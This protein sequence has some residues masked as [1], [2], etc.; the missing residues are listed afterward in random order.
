[1]TTRREPVPS[2]GPVAGTAAGHAIGVAPGVLPPP[3]PAN[4]RQNAP[5][6]KLEHSIATTSAPE[7][8][9]LAQPKPTNELYKRYAEGNG[10]SLET[11]KPGLFSRMISG[12]KEIAHS[13]GEHLESGLKKGIAIG[14]SALGSVKHAVSAAF[15]AIPEWGRKVTSGISS[16]WE[17]VK[18]FVGHSFDT[19]SKGISSFVEKAESALSAISSW[20]SSVTSKVSSWFSSSSSQSEESGFFGSDA[21]VVSY[22]VEVAKQA[23][24]ETEK[25]ALEAAARSEAAKQMVSGTLEYGNDAAVSAKLHDIYATPQDV[26][27]AVAVARERAEAE[28]LKASIAQAESQSRAPGASVDVTRRIQER[29][30][31][32]GNKAS[33]HDLTVVEKEAIKKEASGST[34]AEVADGAQRA[35]ALLASKLSGSSSSAAAQLGELLYRH[36]DDEGVRE[37]LD[38]PSTVSKDRMAEMMRRLNVQISS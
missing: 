34:L 21:K 6:S 16:A 23:A 31:A 14:E 10:A 15:D 25:K 33:H 22:I 27:A 36:R 19:L 11:E 18:D 24:V 17:G 8:E 9:K 5:E 1:M 20:A 28:K 12:A 29:L 26:A 32:D 4:L 13:I 30:G 37:M 7:T 35:Q 2:S 38:S 3:A